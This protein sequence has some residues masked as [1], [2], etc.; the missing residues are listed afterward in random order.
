MSQSAR[1]FQLWHF[2]QSSEGWGHAAALP[3]QRKLGAYIDKANADVARIDLR[4]VHKIDVTFAS[5]ALVE[6]VRQNLGRRALCLTHPMNAD[7]VE[8]IAAAAE[9]MKVPVTIWQG[10]RAHVAGP[11]PGP[12]I[13]DA[14]SYALERV[15]VRTGEYAAACGISSANAS[16]RFKQL[17][18]QGYLL[19]REGSASSGGPEHIYSR[20][21]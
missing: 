20:I 5:T 9:R 11:L 3:I 2:T 4:N 14:L 18:Q 15:A 7:V 12:R 8:N 19:R 6:L 21:G 16:N 10:D 13:G 1:T 17:W